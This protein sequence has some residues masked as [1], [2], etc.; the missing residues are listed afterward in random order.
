MESITRRYGYDKRVIDVH[1]SRG[2]I[3]CAR[4]PASWGFCPGCGAANGGEKI[5]RGFFTNKQS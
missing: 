2:A 4:V 5:T 3:V 1:M